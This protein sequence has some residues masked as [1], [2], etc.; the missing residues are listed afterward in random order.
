MVKYDA[1]MQGGNPNADIDI[2]AAG[3]FVNVTPAYGVRSQPNDMLPQPATYNPAEEKRAKQMAAHDSQIDSVNSFAVVATLLF[4]AAIAEFS[5]FTP[6]D[7]PVVVGRVH[8]VLT[9]LAVGCSLYC[10]VVAVFVVA[11][12]QRMKIFDATSWAFFLDNY[13]DIETEEAGYK[14]IEHK[15]AHFR[16]NDESLKRASKLIGLAPDELVARWQNGDSVA[17]MALR[18]MI[19]GPT[20][21]MGIAY[22]LFPISFVCFLSAVALRVLKDAEMY[23]QVAAGSILC[24]LVL[25]A[26]AM[27]IQSVGILSH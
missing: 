7:W 18:T 2:P 13:N 21:R 11:T 24:A 15:Q 3:A 22:Q 20:T 23:T 25:P 26:C 27:T 8:A 4:G 19:R 6:K 5:S 10:S 1:M 17:I 16:T 12:V 14:S 9:A